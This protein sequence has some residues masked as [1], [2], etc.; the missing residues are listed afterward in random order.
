MFPTSGP[1][2]VA[3]GC[4]AL[5]AAAVVYALVQFWG[6]QTAYADR[7]LILVGSVWAFRSLQP[8]IAKLAYRP[9]PGFGLPILFLGGVAFAP[10]LFL[11]TQIGPRTLLLWWMTT[12]LLTA[13]S[14][15]ALARVG[16]PRWRAALFPLVFVLFALPIPLRVLVPLQ[17]FLQDLTTNLAFR[18]FSLLGF[19]VVRMEYVLELPGGML[20]VE[21]ACSGVRSLTALTAI[22]AFVAFLKGF[23]PIRG[24]GLLALSIPIVLAVN[25][26]RVILSGFIQEASSSDYIKDEWH[27]ALGFAMV[28]VGL[29]IILLIA[30]Q[31]A[32]AESAAIAPTERA[33]ALAERP[34]GGRFAAGSTIVLAV[35]CLGMTWLGTGA[36]T[37]SNESAPLGRIPL[38]LGGWTGEDREVPAVVHEL[39]KSDGVVHR[40]Y[41][42]NVGQEAYVWVFHWQS[43]SAIIGYHHPDV[44]WGNRGLVATDRWLEAVPCG[45]EARIVQVTAREFKQSKPRQ[46]VFYWTQEGKHVWTDDD[47]KA[48][49]REMLTSSWSG[50][51]WV[52]DLLGARTESRGSRLQAMVILPD[53]G[54]MPRKNAHQLARA[55][56]EELYRLCP[57]AMPDAPAALT[58]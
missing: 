28:F 55:L 23:G 13:A 10:A 32:P 9:R 46:L 16:V 54:A 21:E 36:A 24:L 12:A 31:L 52:G 30:R 2:R 4:L 8:S 39:L 3:W 35:L 1:D 19:T 29:G 58:P 41:T 27:E 34:A 17:D 53:A 57:W 15:L 40:R 47:E 18:T 5:G 25:V 22:A 50:H 48:A 44:C 26:L 14:G 49:E 43:G 37:A 11:L 33:T 56:S 38:T 42:N 20:R 45:P 51:K 6:V 7:F